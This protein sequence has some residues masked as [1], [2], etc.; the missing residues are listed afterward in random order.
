M[1]SERWNTGSELKRR[2]RDAADP[3][4]GAGPVVYAANG[5]AY[6]DD[7]ES[8]IAVIGR[9]GTGKSQC[10]SLPDMRNCL[11]KG[12]SF[13]ALDP[14]GELWRRNA[15]YIPENYQVFCLDFRNP[16]ESPTR[17]NPLRAPYELFRS[18]NP[19][20]H[21]IA[22]SM[23]SEFWAGV[24]PI[25]PH[26]DAFWPVA[27]ANYAKGLT[28][29]LFET[30]DEED[31]NLDSIAVMME[32]SELRF[33]S[34]TLLKTFYESLPLHSLARRN[35]AT[36]VTGPNDTR[37]S[38]H[39]VAAAGLEAFSRSRGLMEMLSDDTLDILHID[40]TRPFAF[41][42]I[43]PD[44]TDVYDSLG[45]LVVSQVSQHLIRVAQGMGGRLP[46]RVNVV[47]EELGSIGKAISQLPSLMVASRSR[48]IRLALVLQSLAQLTDI[49]G[50]SKAET[51]ASCIGL[52][53]GFSTNDWATLSEWSG[54]CG[55]RQ[56]ESNGHVSRE[57]LITAAQLA[58]MPTGT[59]LV[60]ADSQVKYIAQLP[61]FHEMYDSSDWQPPQYKPAPRKKPLQSI[62]FE[63]MV[64]ERKRQKLKATLAETSVERKNKPEEFSFD[65]PSNY[66]RLISR[67]DAKIA[68]L[69]AKE[70]DTQE[71]KEGASDP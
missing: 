12:E 17:W 14:K 16:R 42:V 22:C 29:A 34:G 31:V 2:F 35:L 24:Y 32:Q 4:A 8:H 15:C 59:A 67:L 40:V 36:Y 38:I 70:E 57:P 7:S 68:E 71:V 69:K 1:R 54:R 61:F 21:D 23:V 33:G 37:G 13:F 25:D 52:T 62:D 63:T 43:V 18:E 60:M 39:S 26:A 28:Y 30:A 64:K 5:K 46:I 50:K 58:A 44:E 48:N 53:I 27:A 47:V 20:D 45:G 55:E 49:Y 6:L 10:F 3:A 19:A 51:I 9:T 56:A 65:E 41:I 66:D 11:R